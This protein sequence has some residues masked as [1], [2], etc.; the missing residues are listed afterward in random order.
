[1]KEQVEKLIREEV[2]KSIKDYNNTYC[3]KIYI[4]YENKLRSMKVPT[5]LYSSCYMEKILCTIP[6]MRSVFNYK[7]CGSIKDNLTKEQ[8]E[9]IIR[10]HSEEEECSIQESIEDIENEDIK[11][12]AWFKYYD[13][14][15][16]KHIDGFLDELYIHIDDD[17]NVKIDYKGGLLK[18]KF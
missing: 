18:A 4:N 9:E 17:L 14:V 8:Y 7:A 6:D 1:M 12:L 2:A 3:T 13:E 5:P 16:Q 10:L 11:L 15:I